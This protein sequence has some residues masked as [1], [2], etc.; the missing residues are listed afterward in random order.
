MLM[1]LGMHQKVPMY[2]YYTLLR[3]LFTIYKSDR[4]TIDNLLFVISKHNWELK[5]QFE[6]PSLAGCR[7]LEPERGEEE[8][9]GH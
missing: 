5:I 9:C 8:G 4:G 6:H 3:V 1:A 7:K 2:V